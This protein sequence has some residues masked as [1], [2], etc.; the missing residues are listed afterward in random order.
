MAT[1]RTVRKHRAGSAG[2]P[3]PAWLRRLL[4][5]RAWTPPPKP[6]VNLNRIR[7]IAYL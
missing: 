6:A 7:R 1:A 2:R 3:L 5:R 4:G